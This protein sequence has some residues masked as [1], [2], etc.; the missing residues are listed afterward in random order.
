MSV[1]DFETVA[2][3]L[4]SGCRFLLTGHRNPDGD[5]LGSALA[6]AQALEAARGATDGGR[7]LLVVGAG[8]D[9][10]ASKRPE[11]GEVA[12]RLADRVVL[13]NDNPRG[14]DPL[15]IIDAIR[16][17]MPASA[18]VT[19]EPDRATAIARAIDGAQGARFIT[20]LNRALSDIR[21]V[22]L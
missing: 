6:L 22:L 3:L 16:S 13:T 9:R 2:A 7:V 14:E 18:D 1:T 12:A 8:G 11:M 19:V 17:G 15:A 21:R 4:S 10:D 5:S 20:E